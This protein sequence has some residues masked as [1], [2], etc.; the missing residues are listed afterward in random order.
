MTYRV[1]ERLMQSN[2]HDTGSTF[3]DA[4][5]SATLRVACEA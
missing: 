4:V 2:C 5:R 1:A 3:P